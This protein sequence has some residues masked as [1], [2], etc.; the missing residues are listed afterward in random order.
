MH[1]D[2]EGEDEEGLCE[3]ERAG[4]EAVGEQ[5]CQLRGEHGD[6]GRLA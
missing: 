2:E 5:R 3:T 6:A 4:E 1:G